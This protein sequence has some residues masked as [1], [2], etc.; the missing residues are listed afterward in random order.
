MAGISNRQRR[1]V[2]LLAGKHIEGRSEIALD[3]RLLFA[4]EPCFWNRLSTTTG[5]KSVQR[6]WPIYG[7]TS[8]HSHNRAGVD[9]SPPGHYPTTDG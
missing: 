9:A 8:E 7:I 3:A 6:L 1:A 5:N 2:S 4:A